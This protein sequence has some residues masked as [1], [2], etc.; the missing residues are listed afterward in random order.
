VAYRRNDDRRRDLDAHPRDRFPRRDFDPAMGASS[1]DVLDV[2]GDQRRA[3]W[4]RLQAQ[5]N[6]APQWDRTG[7]R[8]DPDDSAGEP[9]FAA[10]SRRGR[11]GGRERGRSG[12][13]DY[14]RRIRRRSARYEG[15]DMDDP[16]QSAMVGSDL[17]ETYQGRYGGVAPYSKHANERNYWAGYDEDRG[18]HRGKGPK[19][20]TRSDERIEEHVCDV[21]LED[22]HVNACEIEVQV[23]NG[24]VTLSGRIDNRSARQRAED[25]VEEV[26]GVKAVRNNLRPKNR[27][28]RWSA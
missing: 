11:H 4:R 9:R 7:Q 14:W 2:E 15:V 20:Y 5:D 24:E 6:P 27:A 25:L 8:K 22:S 17:H 3:R 26:S 19:G 18:P 1:R 21:L 12:D 28:S 16:D 10:N 13:D 23:N